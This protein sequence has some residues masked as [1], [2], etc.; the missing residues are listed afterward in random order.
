MEDL[1]KIKGI[2]KSFDEKNILQNISLNV[3]NNEVFSIF[4]KSGCGKTTLLKIISG[5]YQPDTGTIEFNSATDLNMNV[6][7]L[8]ATVWQSRALYS[9]LNV[10][11]NINFG[12]RFLNISRQEK[13]DRLQEV[14]K[15]LDIENILNR[16][17]NKLS[18]GE[19]QK[20]ALARALIVKPL[21]ILMDE[22]FTGIDS[23]FKDEFR[24]ELRKIFMEFE[25]TFIIVSHDVN[26]VISLSDRILVLEQGII[27]QISTP[28]E[29]I[30]NPKTIFIAQSFGNHNIFKGR[31]KKVES[32]NIAYVETNIGILVAQ[33]TNCYKEGNEVYYAINPSKIK[34]NNE[35]TNSIVAQV[36]KVTKVYDGFI[37]VLIANNN[38]IVL[39]SNDSLEMNSI[40]YN[41]NIS[42]SW[43]MSDAVLLDN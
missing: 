16:S 19:L 7:R 3:K 1:I 29:L 12:L 34:C 27:S 35:K 26:D 15:L 42:I 32:N 22:P 30:F 28:D 4:G 41:N 39:K 31:I 17:I 24:E 43:S 2:S 40:K 13:D 18:G 37:V 5:I 33:T 14:V 20:V 9:H 11:S 23:V 10:K 6:R 25:C 36:V 38:R 21:V 8:T